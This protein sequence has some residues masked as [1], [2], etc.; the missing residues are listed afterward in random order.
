MRH[1]FEIIHAA[2][3]CEG[4]TLPKEQMANMHQRFKTLASKSDQAL[5]KLEY[6][7]M[8][9]RLLAFLVASEAKL[10]VWTSK[11]GH[12]EDVEDM[13]KDYMVSTLCVCVCVCVCLKTTDR[14]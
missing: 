1:E 10:Q 9:Y 3:T 12:Q 5:Y 2:G 6:E 14:N 8:K 7:E 11:L 13:L 4:I